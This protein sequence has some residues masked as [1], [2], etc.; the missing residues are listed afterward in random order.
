MA[1]A[2]LPLEPGSLCRT[3]R[4]Q[5]VTRSILRRHLPVPPPSPPRLL[6]LATICTSHRSTLSRAHRCSSLRGMNLLPRAMISL[7]SSPSARAEAVIGKLKQLLNPPP[8][9]KDE[10]TSTE[11]G[12]WAKDAA[13]RLGVR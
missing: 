13:K 11:I 10:N 3:L 12:E 8:E 1:T 6:I 7:I 4:A 5:E 9:A 2:P